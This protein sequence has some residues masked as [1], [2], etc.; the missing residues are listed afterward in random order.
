M[1][2]TATWVLRRFFS[3]LTTEPLLGCRQIEFVFPL[4]SRKA[5]DDYYKQMIEVQKRDWTELSLN[6]RKARESHHLPLSLAKTQRGLSSLLHRLWSLRSSKTPS[7]RWFQ[8]QN[9]FPNCGHPDRFGPAVL[10][11]PVTPYVDIPLSA[12]CAHSLLYQ[13]SN[14]AQ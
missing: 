14:L 11:D 10:L 13:T 3:L 5:K 4:M 2:I 7:P 6:E 9:L 12:L 1:R 8:H